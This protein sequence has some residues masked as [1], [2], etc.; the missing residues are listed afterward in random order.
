MVEY[1]PPGCGWANRSH[2][3]ARHDRDD[4]ADRGHAPRAPRPHPGRHQDG[5]WK[6]RWKVF[7]RAAWISGQSNFSRPDMAPEPPRCMVC[8]FENMTAGHTEDG[9]SSCCPTPRRRRRPEHRAMAQLHG[10]RRRPSKCTVSFTGAKVRSPVAES[11]W[12]SLRRRH[13]PP[14]L[15]TGRRADVLWLPTPA[16]ATIAMTRR[17]WHSNGR[18]T[19]TT[20]TATISSPPSPGPS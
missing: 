16:F 6:I 3:F 7:T 9:R 4:A 17:P 8:M 1:R 5:A 10:I 14:R 19:G 15:R 2:D 11:A 13:L 12:K 20:P 18:R